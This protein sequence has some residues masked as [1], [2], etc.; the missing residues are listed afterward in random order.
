MTHHFRRK[1]VLTVAMGRA[2]RRVDGG[3][4]LIVNRSHEFCSADKHREI[5]AIE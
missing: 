1:V 2:R 3:A 5:K 4:V